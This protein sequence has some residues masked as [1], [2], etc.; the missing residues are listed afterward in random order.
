MATLLAVLLVAAIGAFW[1]R[2]ASLFTLSLPTLTLGAFSVEAAGPMGLEALLTSVGWLAVFLTADAFARARGLSVATLRAG[3]IARDKPRWLGPAFAVTCLLLVSAIWLNEANVTAFD[4]RKRTSDAGPWYHAANLGIKAFSTHAVIALTVL[5]GSGARGHLQVAKLTLLVLAIVG[6]L[7]SDRGA[8]F[9]PL[10][11]IVLFHIARIRGKVASRLP[12]GRLLVVAALAALVLTQITGDRFGAT[13]RA[14]G[15]A[16][17]ARQ[18]TKNAAGY[19]VSA[20][21]DIRAYDFSKTTSVPEMRVVM[22]GGFYGFVPRVLWPSKPEFVTTGRLTGAHVFRQTSRTARGAGIPCSVAAE[23]AICYGSQF[24]FPGFLL[25]ALLGVAALCIAAKLPYLAFGA[26]TFV[27]GLAS[28]G[29]PK[30][31]F[32]FV[33]TAI[34]CIAIVKVSGIRFTWASVNDVPRHSPSRDMNLATHG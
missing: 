4:S 17:L 1:I 5:R 9:I 25:A 12:L 19:G 34:T 3:T 28:H 8:L 23:V 22:L 7:S 6:F 13:S 20:P 14:E 27:E 29:L 10:I 18:V 24:F 11:T 15:A 32:E 2:N 33:A 26:V 16:V 31:Q 30:S 21:K